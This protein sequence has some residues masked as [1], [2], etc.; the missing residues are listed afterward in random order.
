VGHDDSRPQRI[1]EQIREQL[2]R[3]RYSRSSET[4]SVRE[5]VSDDSDRITTEIQ[6][7]LRD[8]QN[9]KDKK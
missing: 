7:A 4:G 2:E 8:A 3:E 6:N 9:A 5:S 1:A